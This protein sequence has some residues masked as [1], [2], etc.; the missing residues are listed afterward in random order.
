MLNATLVVPEIQSTTSSKGIRLFG[1][2]LTCKV[3]SLDFM[4][5]YTHIQIVMVYNFYS[6]QFKSFAY[7]YNEEQFMAALEKDINIVRTLPKS[8]KWARKK[9]AIP[10][11]RVPYLA[12]PYYFLHHVLPILVKHSVV[13]LVVSHGGCLE[14]MRVPIFSHFK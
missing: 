6:S 7:L 1:P 11:F 9:K 4:V 8:L 3:T 2:R 14:V 12:S 10:V 13:E 5:F